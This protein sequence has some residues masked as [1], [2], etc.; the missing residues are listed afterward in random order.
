M[1]QVREYPLPKAMQRLDL[2]GAEPHALEGEI[3]ELAVQP[4]AMQNDRFG[5]AETR[6]RERIAEHS[7]PPDIT[8]VV[9]PAIAFLARFGEALR[10]AMLSSKGMDW[11]PYVRPPVQIGA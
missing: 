6:H 4:G 7:R 1:M 11:W 10:H 2:R 9:W 5:M 8:G 3:A